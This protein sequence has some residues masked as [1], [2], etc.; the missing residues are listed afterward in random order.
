VDDEA[1]EE[2]ARAILAVFREVLGRPELGPYD[3][4]FEQGGQSLQLIQAANRLSVL[5]AREVPAKT[6]LAQPSAAALAAALEDAGQPNVESP[7]A[8]M[9]ADSA[10]LAELELARVSAPEREARQVLL[11]GATGFVGAQLLRALLD[12]TPARV[13]CLVRAEDEASAKLRLRRALS[14]QG[15]S[16]DGL[17]ERV[18]AL[19]ADLARAWL[20]LSEPAFRRLAAECDAIYHN[21]AAVSLVRP[22]G[23]VR[24]TNVLATAEALRFAACERLKPLHHVS[25]LAVAAGASDAAVLREQFV[26]A[27]AGLGDGY[28]QT[29]WVAE[30]LVQ[31]ALARGVSARV[32]RLGRVVGSVESAFVN[33]DDIIWRLLRAS[34]RVGLAPAFE[35]SEP[36]SPADSVAR[37]IVRIANSE[38]PPGVYHVT[39]GDKVSLSGLFGALREFG[40][41]LDT[42]DSARFLTRL[43][44]SEDADD[45]ATCAFFERLAGVSAAPTFSIESEHA[46][47]ALG[48]FSWPRIQ[49]ALLRRYFETCVREGHFPPPNSATAR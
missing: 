5:L 7:R 49:G 8:Q 23:S 27:H 15:L 19:P 45:R 1:L 29:K 25:T 48:D 31:A 32:Y 38:A 43:R 42:V 16:L 28:T 3:D 6:V 36:W 46:A 20:G 47:R 35:L 30:A 39:A 33:A 21:A 24:A 37:A 18:L 40:Y 44:A 26:S 17:S 13:V 12:T 11:T 34:V 9:L 14:R 22:Y 10:L 2:P 41:K 4:F